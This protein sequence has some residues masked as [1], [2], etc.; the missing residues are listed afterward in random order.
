MLINR[1]I[2]KLILDKLAGEPKVIILYGPRQSGKTVILHEI[3]NKE[4]KNNKEVL[5]LKGD[6]VRVQEVF[7]I[8]DYDK[9]SKFI[10]DPNIL[11]IDEAQKIENIGSSLKLL[12]DSRPIHI[13]A[14][15]SAS[16]DLANKINEPL[17][18]RATFFT[19]Y[20]LSVDE[21]RYKIPNFGLS[22]RLEE[23]LR[24]GMYPKV[25]TLGGQKEKE[26]YLYDIINTYLY[27]DL[28]SF[29]DI[30]KPKKIFDLLSLLSLQLGSEVSV[31]ELSRNLFLHRSTVEKYLD[32]LGKM[33]IIINIRGFSRNLRKEISK[34]SK[35]YFTDLGFRNSIIR[36]FNP[37]KLRAD[38]GALFENFG[39]LE[40]IKLL[41]NTK[42][43]A[44][45]YFWRTYDQKEIDFIEEKDGKLN[46][47]EFKF[48]DGKIPRATKKEFLKT[49]PQ[50]DLKLIN[51]ENIEEFL[52]LKKNF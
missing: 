51:R 32:I 5:F 47:F 39:I 28:L 50:S 35:Y 26:E 38:A 37:L 18:G 45:F 1:I 25:H 10:G 20:P 16:F 36:N 52:V 43:H 23:F 2:T 19:A 14:S 48:G 34:T 12:F 27:Q 21:T 44:N 7:G 40:R 31:D 41:S 17:T 33:F 42:K 3:A 46:A 13:I 22:S 6:D 30:K 49:Y 8:A 11:I 9:I 15:G 29:Q 24:F 4:R